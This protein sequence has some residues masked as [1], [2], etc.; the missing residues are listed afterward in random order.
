MTS[1][2]SLTKPKHAEYLAQDKGGPSKGGFP[3]NQLLSYTDIYIYHTCIYI[4][5][6]IYICNEL[7]GMCV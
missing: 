3:N 4:Y 1:M 7:D 2:A 6:Y 5:I